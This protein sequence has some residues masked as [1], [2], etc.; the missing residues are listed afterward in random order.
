[1]I[2]RV[3]FLIILFALFSWTDASACTCESSTL[4]CSDGVFYSTTLTPLAILDNAN[5]GEPYTLTSIGELQ[6]G[7]GTVDLTR[8]LRIPLAKPGILN[9]H[10]VIL[11]DV[12]YSHRS[13]IS[14]L[15]DMDP[16]IMLSDGISA[17]GF[18]THDKVNFDSDSPVRSCEGSSGP[19]LGSMSC[20]AENIRVTS[21]PATV[22]TLHFRLEPQKQASGVIRG[23]YDREVSVFRQYTKILKPERGLV[24][25]VYR[26][27]APEQY[28]FSFFKITA[29]VER[30]GARNCQETCLNDIKFHSICNGCS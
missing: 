1:M 27:D 13:P 23:S 2:S 11:V 3:A 28:V 26:H 6:F 29:R 7:S 25:E 4:D 8:L 5:I 20:P 17:V 12:V 18:R 10:R 24:L 30:T 15:T 14:S 9:E 16:R 19:T 22:H 21:E